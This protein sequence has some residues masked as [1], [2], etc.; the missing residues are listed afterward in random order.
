MN[1]PKLADKATFLAGIIDDN[2]DRSD[3]LLD[4]E[5]PRIHNA[6]DQREEDR[7]Y[8]LVET[9][10]LTDHHGQSCDHGECRRQQVGAVV[11]EQLGKPRVFICPGTGTLL[12]TG[13]L[14]KPAPRS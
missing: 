9:T 11:V 6:A 1:G 3:W 7:R 10:A 8:H 13:G 14:Q 2:R 5:Q 12:P 4:E